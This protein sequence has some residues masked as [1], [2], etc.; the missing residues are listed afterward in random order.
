MANAKTIIKAR[1]DAKKKRQINLA[2]YENDAEL[3]AWLMQQPNRNGY[4]KRLIRKDMILH[5]ANQEAT[6]A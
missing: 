1:Y 2:F 4:L 5:R 3:Y 6:E